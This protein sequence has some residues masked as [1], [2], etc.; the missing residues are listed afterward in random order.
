MCKE[1]KTLQTSLADKYAYNCFLKSIHQS[2]FKT[3]FNILMNSIQLAFCSFR[4]SSSSVEAVNQKAAILQLY[5]TKII[6]V[7]K[8]RDVFEL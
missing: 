2:Y 6:D 4:N 1:F 8:I 7:Y 3:A 5:D